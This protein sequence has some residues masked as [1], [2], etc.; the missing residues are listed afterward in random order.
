MD[1]PFAFL[2][3]KKIDTSCFFFGKSVSNEC[4]KMK[5]MIEN[6]STLTNPHCILNKGPLESRNL[7]KVSIYHPFHGFTDETS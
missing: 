4:F 6:A 3:S 7:I 5:R 2:R 1:N